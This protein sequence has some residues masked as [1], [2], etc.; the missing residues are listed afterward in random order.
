M[1]RLEQGLWVHECPLRFMGLEVG[2]R[3]AVVE[4]G[5][6]ALW[7]NSPAPLD[8]A[9]RRELDGIGSV[10]FVTPSSLLHGHIS[11]GDYA[12]AFAE[13]E[14]FSVPGLERKRADLRFAGELGEEPE[15]RWAGV[16]D[17]TFVAGLRRPIERESR[18]GGRRPAS[19]TASRR[20]RSDRSSSRASASTCSR[21]FSSLRGGLT[22]C[23]G[24]GVSVAGASFGTDRA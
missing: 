21:A 22:N 19:A 18:S 1:R 5:D 6:G 11:M 4:L 12:E 24:G 8:Q 2:R 7:I 20:R 14:L 23:F 16:L 17:Q 9:L 3:M 10:R 15:P 13:A